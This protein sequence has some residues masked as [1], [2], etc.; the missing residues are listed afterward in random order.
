MNTIITFIIRSESLNLVIAVIHVMSRVQC[1]LIAT[2]VSDLDNLKSSEKYY[3]HCSLLQI[4]RLL[5]V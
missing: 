2:I 3:M 5:C 4:V 1:L